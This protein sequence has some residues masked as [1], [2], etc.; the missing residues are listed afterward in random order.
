VERWTQATPIGGSLQEATKEEFI[1]QAF[2]VS[3][4][5]VAFL[6][7]VSLLVICIA[8]LQAKVFRRNSSFVWFSVYLLV[9]VCVILLLSMFISPFILNGKYHN[10]FI[11]TLML[12]LSIFM[13]FKVR[14][15]LRKEQNIRFPRK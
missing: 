3:A 10:L 1:M 8:V 14:K 7:I 11:L 5:P 2:I 13:T 6:I 12:I 15:L 4:F 9:G